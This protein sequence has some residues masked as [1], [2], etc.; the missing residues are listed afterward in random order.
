[1]AGL[2][3]SHVS[4]NVGLNEAIPYKDNK[5]VFW[6]ATVGALLS[7]TLLYFVAYFGLAW[8]PQSIYQG[9]ISPVIWLFLPIE[10]VTKLRYYMWLA[11]SRSYRHDLNGVAQLIYAIPTAILTPLL[12]WLFLHYLQLSFE[13]IFAV[14]SI[15]GMVQWLGTEIYFNIKLNQKKI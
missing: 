6:K 11:I 10:I 1:M 9:L 8:L 7:I 2:L 3:N 12:L 15:I 5:F 4:R 14:G 13:S